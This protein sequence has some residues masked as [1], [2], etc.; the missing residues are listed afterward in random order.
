MLKA[1]FGGSVRALVRQQQ[2]RFRLFADFR[3]HGEAQARIA[4]A[5]SVQ[6]TESA[7]HHQMSHSIVSCSYD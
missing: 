4:V 2:K 3:P 6:V 1:G 5:M 7:Q